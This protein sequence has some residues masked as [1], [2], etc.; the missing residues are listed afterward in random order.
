MRGDFTRDTRERARRASTRAV[1]LQQ[2]RQLL[3]TDWN[4]Q[5]GL[6]A[7]REEQL[8]RHVIG[9]QG[10]PRDDAGFAITSG[11]NFGIGAGSLYAEGLHV[12]N[13]TATSYTAQSSIAGLLPSL[14]SILA[15]GA[16][17]LVYVEALLR[18]ASLTQDPNLSE[19]ALAGAD[20]VVREN[21]AWTV[22]VVPLA[23][24]GMGRSQLIT[25][26]DTNQPVTIT[27]WQGTT[28]GLDADVQ[29]EA[30]ATDPSPCEMPPTAGYLDQLNRLY[31][32]E[33]HTSGAQGVATFKWS[34]DASAEAG[35]RAQGAGFAIDLPMAHAAELFG[36]GAIVELIDDVRARLGLPGDMGAI[37]SA[38]GDP[39]AINGIAAASLSASVR[40]RR[41]ASMPLVIPAGSAWVNLSKGIKIRFAT[42]A[43]QTGSA[44]TIPGRTLV[45]DILWPPY[46]G[47]DLTQVVAAQNVGFFR[48]TEGRRRYAALAIIQRNGANFNVQED[49][50]DL[51]PPLTDI[52]AIDVRFDDSSSNLGATN[53]Q[54]AIDALAAR[55]SLCC[56]YEV[57]P[58]AGWWDV[59]AD[60]PQ[61]AHA[62]ICF[63][64]G[65]Y[66]LSQA[67]DISRLGH[68]RFRGA[69]QGTKIWCYGDESAL[70]F[71]DCASVEIT[72]MLI[73]AERRSPPSKLGRTAGAVDIRNCGPVRIERTSMI[74]AGTRW[75][76]SACLRVDVMGEQTHGGA[77]N[78]TVRDC[79]I[80]G[81]DLATGVLIL[82]GN[83]VRVEGNRFRVREEGSDRTFKRWSDDQTMAASMGR[84]LFSFPSS[85]APRNIPIRR[86]DDSLFLSVQGNYGAAGDL[87]HYSSILADEE[88]WKLFHSTYAQSLFR[89][90]MASLVT[91][92]RI[93][94]ANLWTNSGVLVIDGEAFDGFDE[95][96]R[97][98]NDTIAPAMD[99]AI[100]IA[101]D[102]AVDTQIAGNM[103]DGA[104]TGIRVGLSTGVVGRRVRA[105][106]IRIKDNRIRIRVVPTD[107]SRHGIQI[108]NV[109][110]L[111]IAD[112]DVADEADGSGRGGRRLQ[113]AKALRLD[114]LHSEG[115]RIHG[116]LGQVV[117]VRGN[118]VRGLSVSYALTA[119]SGTDESQKQWLFQGNHARN[120]RYDYRVDDR[121]NLVDNV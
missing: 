91:E 61:N 90:S 78:I 102:S 17:G 55:D 11:S 2:G 97:S 28:G 13:A 79:D 72:D 115:I 96:Y 59:F 120:F 16:E 35:L 60:I 74:G 93:M 94:M 46:P 20:T 77:G 118:S 9:R 31:R 113:D 15:D 70:R 25:A 105:E 38:P 104:L 71:S 33:I 95:A 4:E 26:L 21:I 119:T 37:T 41:W 73:A 49:L 29:T 42:G 107:M 75:R 12:R 52:Q 64:P 34:E 114:A 6:T 66:D 50:R 18:P 67:V 109:N 116:S 65:N 81:G 22:R 40:I 1:L 112:N 88:A 36:T 121:C 103:I 85:R 62:T 24:I 108:G 80:V 19:P 100:V 68:V 3:D 101:G 83:K 30:E 117:H 84:L 47:A 51:F 99:T 43:Y 58:G 106:S 57:R 45:G 82:N 69:G 54:E 111:W 76:Q 14:T 63:G 5:A 39:L 98:V 7:D 48:P 44:W 32:V 92:I 110:R 87:T 89:P 86:E 27:P 8:A 10:A 23:G 56:T 53:V